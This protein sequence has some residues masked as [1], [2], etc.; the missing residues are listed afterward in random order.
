MFDTSR[1][2][3]YLGDW[4]EALIVARRGGHEVTSQDDLPTRHLAFKAGHVH[5]RL[6]EKRIVEVQE[7]FQTVQQRDVVLEEMG[8]DLCTLLD[9]LRTPQGRETLYA[10]A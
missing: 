9:L 7:W 8:M 1:D 3:A 2:Y 6:P 10:K 5:H 4:L